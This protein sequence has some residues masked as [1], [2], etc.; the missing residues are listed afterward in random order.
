MTGTFLSGRISF[1]AQ[2][3]DPESVTVWVLAPSNDGFP[4]NGPVAGAINIGD[5][6]AFPQTKGLSPLP[7]TGTYTILVDATGLDTGIVKVGVTHL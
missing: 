7:E 4:N 1:S 3:V 2:I 5:M 6:N